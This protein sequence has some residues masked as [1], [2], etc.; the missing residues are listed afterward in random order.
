MNMNLKLDR[1]FQIVIQNANNNKLK[2]ILKNH[3]IQVSKFQQ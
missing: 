3:N 1:K 2:E